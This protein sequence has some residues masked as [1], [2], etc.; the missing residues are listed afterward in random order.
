VFTTLCGEAEGVDYKL[1]YYTDNNGV[2]VASNAATVAKKLSDHWGVSVSYLVDAI[3]GASR[4]DHHGLK[5][6]TSVAPDAV[7]GAT[8]SVTDAV[9]SATPTNELRH[10]VS[11]TLSLTN[12]FIKMMSS[13][14]N[15]DDPTVASL[16]GINSQE[17]DY[18]SR[19][20]SL[21]LSQDLFQRNTTIGV[22]AGKSFDLYS[23]ATRFLAA[24]KYLS[25]W[26]YFGDGQRQTDNISLSITQGLSVTTIATCN[27]GYVFDRGYLGRPYYVYKIGDVY[28]HE[29][30]PDQKKSLTVAGILNQYIP[31]GTGIAVRVEYRYYADSWELTSHTV[32]AEVS[33]RLGDYFIVRPLYR[34]YMQTGTFFYK[35]LYDS[36]DFYLTTDLKYRGGVTQT[37]GI[38]LSWELRDFVKPESAGI[39]ALYPVAIDIAANYYRR[40]GPNDAAVLRSH[41]AYFNN[42]FQSLW[43]QTGIRCTF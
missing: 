3:T 6:D 14:K 4:R 39:F 25:G 28:N 30:V 11:G 32:G 8:K 19:T 7:S 42:E 22:R 17:N 12:D 33:F 18:T 40:S 16:T 10:Q 37:A 31:L 43:I 35:D 34:Y 1:Q 27:V 9:T 21:A 23:P 15:N 20:V 29:Q 26:N 36:A 13:D 24:A 5:P 2:Q 41:Y 38:K